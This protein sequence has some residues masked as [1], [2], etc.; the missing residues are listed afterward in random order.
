M[1]PNR[2]LVSI[3]VRSM[4]RPS[5]DRALDSAAMQT[6]SNLE[7]V[8]VAACGKRHR[9]LPDSWK[10][11]RL[12]F[13]LPDRDQPLTRPQAA[14][15]CLDAASGE[16]LNFLDDDDE[17]LPDHVKSLLEA[18]RL[19]DARVLYASARIHDLDG[20][21]VGYS[22]REGMHIQLYNQNRNQPVATLFH[23]SLVDEGARFDPTFP[24]YEDHDFFI[25]C[26]TRTPFQWVQVANCVW[27][28]F[29]G[30]SGCGFGENS[31]DAERETYYVRLREKWRAAFDRWKSEPE[32]LIYL[33]QQHLKAGDLKVALQSLE[34]ALTAMPGNANALNLCGMANFH[35]GNV[36][37][38][39]QLLMQAD[40]LYPGQPT[41]LANINLVRSHAATSDQAS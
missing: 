37:R 40:R 39:L 25:N 14:N 6:W 20:K 34:G 12:R 1:T 27:N 41:L 16:W 23:R 21:L 31:N 3:L 2:P 11:R 19:D 35:A 17:F 24:I 32:S 29:S 36:D 8:V 13:V 5:L 33:G 18:Q 10:G 15:A 7:I 30:D 4:D 9:P 22:G 38:A 26:A 28:G